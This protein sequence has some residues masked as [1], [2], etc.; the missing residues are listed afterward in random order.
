LSGARARRLL[1]SLVLAGALLGWLVRE[2]FE[3]AAALRWARAAG[4][5]VTAAGE[6]HSM[7]GQS[8]VR[9]GLFRAALGGYGL[10]GVILEARLEVV[11]NVLYRRQTS[12][13]ARAT[14]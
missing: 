8:F 4:L 11:P 2:I 12:R 9:N 5:K 7:G 6:R 10:M 1:L 3:Q 13:S 14:R